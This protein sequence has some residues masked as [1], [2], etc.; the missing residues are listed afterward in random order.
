MVIKKMTSFKPFLKPKKVSSFHVQDIKKPRNV[1]ECMFAFNS[2]GEVLYERC[3]SERK[4][5]LNLLGDSHG[6]RN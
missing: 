4:R 3:K 1:A 6:E 5:L 2:K